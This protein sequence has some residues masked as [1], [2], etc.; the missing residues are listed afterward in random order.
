LLNPKII[1]FLPSTKY[2]QIG[3]YLLLE[4]KIIGTKR[5]DNPNFHPL[6]KVISWKVINSLKF[7]SLKIIEILILILIIYLKRKNNLKPSK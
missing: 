2:I 5:S 4:Y 6:I 1:V 3:D 7:W